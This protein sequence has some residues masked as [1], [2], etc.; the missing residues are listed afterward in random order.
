MK[1]SQLLLGICLVCCL[2]AE[3]RTQPPVLVTKVDP[4]YRNLT[5]GYLVD[6]AE[7]QITLDAKGV[8]FAL[9]SA[10]GLPD[11]V[12][13]ALS[14]WRYRPYKKDGRHVPCSFTIKL[15]IRRAITPFIERHI[16][17]AW[18]PTDERVREAIEKGK[19]L[20]AGEAAQLERDLPQAEALG[21]P[22]T[23]L[24][25]YY[26]KTAPDA[27]TARAARARLIAWLIQ[28]CPDDEILGSPA[29]MINASGE[30][31]AD[32]QAQ[33]QAKQLWLDAWAKAANSPTVAEHAVNF[34]RTVDPGRAIQILFGLR[35]WPL[36]NAWIGNVYGL[37]ALGV[38]AL[39]PGHGRA[40]AVDDS[41]PR[42]RLAQ[43]VQ[44]ALL[45]SDEARNV[46]S[47]MATVESAHSSLS[48]V[49]LWTPAR[50][51][52]CQ[53]LLDHTKTVYPATSASCDAAKQ[54]S[55]GDALPLA[56]GKGTDARAMLRKK[57][58]PTYPSAAKS[59]RVQGTVK[60]SAVID[61]SGQNQQ[62]ELVSGPLALYDASRRAVL[63]WEY[64]PAQSNGRPIAVSTQIEVNFSLGY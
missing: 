36:R 48:K 22:R 39:D 54:G 64:S 13:Q 12:V 9:N 14:Q 46:L 62:L 51:E 52:F 21:H 50:Q 26:A 3:D 45:K 41:A 31:L 6:V 28:N 43:S 58:N 34:L 49:Q 35:D 63:E 53:Q 7:V 19:Q 17:P 2:L 42:L 40:V 16:R 61:E 23:S 4:D 20:T 27:A 5:A 44:S 38:S 8:P 15:P 11:N 47:A 60:F 1:V 59:K 37:A 33:A 57:V 56:Q 32:A 10:V 25:I 29:A 24:L 18:A 30:P 55:K